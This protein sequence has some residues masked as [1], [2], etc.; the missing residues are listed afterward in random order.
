MEKT[1]IEILKHLHHQQWAELEYRRRREVQVFTWSA[2]VLLAV[3]GGV[4]A[5]DGSSV[6]PS[7]ETSWRW[8]A[9]V[10]VVTLTVFSARWQHHHRTAAAAHKRILVKIALELGAYTQGLLARSDSLY[11]PGWLS[12]GKEVRPRGRVLATVLVA[13]AAVLSIWWDVLM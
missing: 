10:V 4:L 9:S 2:T 1:K 8:A 5:R 7:H 3:A 13:V 6:L 11:P 12:W